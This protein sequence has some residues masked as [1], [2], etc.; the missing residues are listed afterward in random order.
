MAAL[1]ETNISEAQLRLTKLQQIFCSSINLAAE[2]VIR[3]CVVYLFFILSQL[4]P[5][6]L[7]QNQQEEEYVHSLKSSA[8]GC[9]VGRASKKDSTF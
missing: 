3:R 8:P 1:K 9:F 6:L 5:H 7:T 4:S 2:G